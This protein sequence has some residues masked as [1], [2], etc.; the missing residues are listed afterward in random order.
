MVVLDRKQGG[1]EKIEARGYSFVSVLEP[2][3]NGVIQV[4]GRSVE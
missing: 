1:R 3:E 2:D 4:S